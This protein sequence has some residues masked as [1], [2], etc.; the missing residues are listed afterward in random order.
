MNNPNWGP[1]S[2]SLGNFL[3]GIFLGALPHMKRG[4]Q[5][6]PFPRARSKILP[7]KFPKVKVS[8]LS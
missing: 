1:K 6:F 4:S 2:F 5:E 7:G 3:K 8:P